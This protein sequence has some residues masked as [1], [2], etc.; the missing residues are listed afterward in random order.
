VL[1]GAT[2]G[3]GQDWKPLPP[4]RRCPSKWGA[5]DE[6]GAANHASPETVLKAARLIREGKVYE[7]GRVLEPAMP[8]F[9]VR[10]FTLYTLRTGGPAG[11]NQLRGNEETVTTEL[12][13]VGTQFDALPHIGISDELYNCNKTDALASRTG[14]TKLGVEKVGALFTRAVMLDVAAAKGVPMLDVGYEITVADLEAA[15]RRQGASIERG[16]AVLI[17]TGWG[18]LW[19]KDN[20]RY[21][22]GQP[23]LGIAAAEWLVKLD[24]M[25]VGSDNWGIEVRPNPNKDLVFPVHQIFITTNGIF[26]LENLDLEGMAR[27]KVSEAAFIIQPLKLKGGTG[28]SVAPIAVK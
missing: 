20:A 27:D 1:L 14:F 12:G 23:G 13:Q 4:E 11:P 10:K 26:L 25:L 3:A 22:S 21:N 5:A 28:S 16:D 15:M 19:L 9:G 24:P 17:R 8:L 18:Q 2:A 6:R 7:L